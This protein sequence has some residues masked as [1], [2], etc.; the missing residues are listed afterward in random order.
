MNDDLGKLDF[1]ESDVRQKKTGLNSA[2][3]DT[4]MLPGSY[5]HRKYVVCMLGNI[6]IHI[7]E[8]RGDVTHAG[9]Q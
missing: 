7:V 8:M 3:V 9:R 1:G 2:Y 4:D 6:M 5:P